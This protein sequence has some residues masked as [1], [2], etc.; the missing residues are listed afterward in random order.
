MQLGTREYR[1]S[2]TRG[3]RI[4]SK[5]SCTPHLGRTRHTILLDACSALNAARL[6]QQKLFRHKELPR[7]A[8]R[9]A[10][11]ARSLRDR[12]GR[13]MRPAWGLGAHVAAEHARRDA[14][15]GVGDSFAEYFDRT[16]LGLLAEAVCH[17]GAGWVERGGVVAHGDV[18]SAREHDEGRR[19]LQRGA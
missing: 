3:G 17:R 14:T 4:L 6:L 13:W 5:P 19:H 18:Q 1:G 12:D 9:P 8:T 16:C 10:G 2:A 11:C 7:A 15:G